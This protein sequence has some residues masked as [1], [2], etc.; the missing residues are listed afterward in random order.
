MGN[1]LTK[2]PWVLDT[3]GATSSWPYPVRILKMIWDQP[4]SSGDDILVEEGSGGADIWSLKA[5][6]GGT[7]IYYDEEFYGVSYSSFY[8]TTL[9]SGT[10]RVYIA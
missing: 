10:L 5:L 1:D 7:G 9:D 2:N 4:D 8:L 6:A 3:D